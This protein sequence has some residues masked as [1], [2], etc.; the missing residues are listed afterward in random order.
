[1][2]RFSSD[3]FVLLNADRTGGLVGDEAAHPLHPGRER[4]EHAASEEVSEL[5]DRVALEDLILQDIN[6][7]AEASS[8]KGSS[9]SS[10]SQQKQQSEAG[11]RTGPSWRG[12]YAQGRQSSGAVLEGLRRL[13]DAF[14]ATQAVQGLPLSNT[15]LMNPSGEANRDSAIEV[16]FLQ[17]WNRS[18]C[19]LDQQLLSETAS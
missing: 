9:A 15:P 5:S 1:M 18:L 11:T 10:H 14:E 17:W 6:E 2:G 13:R 12:G 7:A 19:H 16:D 8:S 4:F 3:L